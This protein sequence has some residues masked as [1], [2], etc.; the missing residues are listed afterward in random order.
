[1][2]VYRKPSALS[3]A[4]IPTKI[5]MLQPWSMRKTTYSA[6]IALPLHGRGTDRCCPGCVRL[7]IL[8]VS[9]LNRLVPMVP[10]CCAICRLQALM[11]WKLRRQ[12]SKIAA[13]GEG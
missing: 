7:E 13:D 3:V 10:D 11:S 5:Y 2:T 4:W 1:M 8:R 12:I 9:V 6:L